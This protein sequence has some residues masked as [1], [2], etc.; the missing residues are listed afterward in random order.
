MAKTC[1]TCRS[2]YA[3]WRCAR[4]DI[5]DADP[6]DSCEYHTKRET[7]LLVDE[8]AETTQWLLQWAESNMPLLEHYCPEVQEAPDLVQ[9]DRQHFAEAHRV[10]ARHQKEVGDA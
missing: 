10:L 5:F 1:R 7:P 6:N 8:L 2:I 3:L 9:I 4:P